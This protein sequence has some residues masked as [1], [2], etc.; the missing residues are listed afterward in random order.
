MLLSVLTQ[1]VV[2]QVTVIVERIE[3][4]FEGWTTR[5]TSIDMTEV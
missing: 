3:P 2:E 4:L 1:Y 5:H